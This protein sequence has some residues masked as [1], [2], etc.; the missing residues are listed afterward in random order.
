MTT[1]GI[2]LLVSVVVVL[3]LP[4]IAQRRVLGTR[5]T[6]SDEQLLALFDS[7]SLPQAA[8]LGILKQIGEGYGIP[9]AKL[10]PGDCFIAQLSK[11]DSWRFDAG[12]ER[13]EI[14]LRERYQITLPYNLTRF[15]I[16]DLLK[17]VENSGQL[18]V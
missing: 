10:R 12:A 4:R 11:I 2:I 14:F 5:E 16:A 6:I 15:T 1:L 17:L 9:Y 3:V 13:L 7:S 18:K 8:R